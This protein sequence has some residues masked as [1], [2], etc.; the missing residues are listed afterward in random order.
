MKV[1]LS[2]ILM[3][4]QALVQ[5]KS[6]PERP[7]EF[8][9]KLAYWFAR[10]EI[11]I[12]EPVKAFEKVR[13]SLFEKYGAKT[14]APGAEIWE[15]HKENI[16]TFTTEINAITEQDEEIKIEPVA[17]ALFEGNETFT[18]EF[19]VLMRDFIKD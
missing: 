7:R 1:K 4:S 13:L 18:T 5:T 12:S 19:F 9:A 2:A 16:E 15:V 11:E 3:A 10:F 8:S 14:G 6:S 17:I